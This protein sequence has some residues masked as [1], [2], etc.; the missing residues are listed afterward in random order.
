M[1]LLQNNMYLEKRPTFVSVI[2]W[3]WITIG[4]FMCL[5]V[6]MVSFASLMTGNIVQ[7]ESPFTFNTFPMLSIVLIGVAVLGIVSGINF[8]K[9]K[10]WPRKILQILTWLLL[11]F[12]IGLGGFWIFSWFIAISRFG[13][14]GLSIMSLF[15]VIV[16]IGIYVIPLGIM[17][18]Y[19]RKKKVHNAI[20]GSIQQGA[21][22]NLK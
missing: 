4:S 6:P 7:D 20:I 22:G 8:L 16:M 9:L 5:V 14:I 1:M 10:L 2:N 17:L 15:M 21:G 3:T 11:I 19:L 18:K 12:I 13:Q